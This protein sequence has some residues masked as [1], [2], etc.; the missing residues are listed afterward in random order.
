[1]FHV[2]QM[3]MRFDGLIGFPGGGVDPG[4]SPVDAVNREIREEIGWTE[5]NGPVSEGDYQFTHADDQNKLV[6][7]FYATEVS[8]S[9]MTFIE[10]NSLKAIDF[11]EEVL[12]NFRVPLYTMGDSYR[13]FPA[14]LKNNFVGNAKGQLLQSLINLDILSSDSISMALQQKRT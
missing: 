10:Q 1:M 2:F 12:G 5:I 9:K 14:F 11:G 3:Q 6:L 7:H 4:E 8:E 13:G